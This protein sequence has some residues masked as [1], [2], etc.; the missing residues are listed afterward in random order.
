M[1]QLHIDTDRLVLDF[2]EGFSHLDQPHYQAYRGLRTLVAE[3]I[4]SGSL[5]L[6]HETAHP[7]GGVHW[8]PD[9]APGL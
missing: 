6:L 1:A 7:T 4:A 9:N 8:V 2:G 5:P 3:H